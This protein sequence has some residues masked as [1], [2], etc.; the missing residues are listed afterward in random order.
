MIVLSDE[1]HNILSGVVAVVII[2]VIISP[3]IPMLI[4]ANYLK[5]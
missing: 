4:Y 1:T 5:S 2:I 3:W